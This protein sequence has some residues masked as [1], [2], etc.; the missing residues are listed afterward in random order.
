MSGVFQNIDPPTPHSTKRVCPLPAPKARGYTLAGRWRGGGRKTPDIGL[1]SY[2][3]IPL[4]PSPCLYYLYILPA[5]SHYS[6]RMSGRKEWGAG[7]VGGWGGDRR[8]GPHLSGCSVFVCSPGRRRR[9]AL[10]MTARYVEE[11]RGR[12]RSP[13]QVEITN[14]I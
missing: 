11:N 7:E 13:L 1:D 2:S 8:G 6:P 4:R 3:I 5:T 12:E 10:S 14:E 9:A